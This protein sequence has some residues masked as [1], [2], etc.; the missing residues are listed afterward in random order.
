M[1]KA[2]YLQVLTGEALVEYHGYL[3]EICYAKDLKLHFMDTNTGEERFVTTYSELATSDKF[4][5]VKRS[6][7]TH[8]A[9]D[10]YDIVYD[11]TDDT[12]AELVNIHEEYTGSWS[13]LQ[14]YIKLMR[15]H[16]CYNVEATVIGW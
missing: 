7:V 4:E 8:S 3:C 5:Y 9:R 10:I 6:E 16:G 14:E 1:K 2:E 15:E 12:G 11:Y 13:D